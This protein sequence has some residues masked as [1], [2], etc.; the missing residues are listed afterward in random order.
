MTTYLL[1]QVRIKDPEVYQKYTSGF[2]AV[3]A[4]YDGKLLA[5][6]DAP[7]MLEGKATGERI[8]ILQFADRAAA[9]RW[10]ESPEYREMVKY[11]HA[12]TDSQVLMVRGFVPRS[13]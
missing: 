6:D 3:L 2:L 5:V 8:V 4:K 13:T 10:W 12:A 9:Q 7:E 1:G 11:R